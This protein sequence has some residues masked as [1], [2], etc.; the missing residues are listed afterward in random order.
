MRPVDEPPGADPHA[1][2]CGEGRLEAGPYPISPRTLC[3]LGR[4]ARLR[5]RTGERSSVH[6]IP[7]SI[8]E[9]F[10]CALVSR[11]TPVTHASEPHSEV[12]RRS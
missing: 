3:L 10:L 5:T 9:G 2:W 1:G 8:K 12:G 7:G 11:A 6:E 4:T